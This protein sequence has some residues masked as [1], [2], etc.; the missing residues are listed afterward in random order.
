MTKGARWISSP[1]S[2]RQGTVRILHHPDRLPRLVALF[3]VFL[4]ALP[5]VFFL[6]SA[7][8]NAGSITQSSARFVLPYALRDTV[9][10]SCG[11]AILSA[12]MGAGL[13]SLVTF[14]E[15]PGVRILRFASILPLAFPTYLIAY[16]LVDIDRPS[17]GIARGSLTPWLWDYVGFILPEMRSLSGAILTFSLVLFPY[18][19]LGARIAFIAQ[20]GALIETAR[21]LGRTPFEIYR[22]IL[23]PLALPAIAAST[24]LVVMESLNDIG[25]SEYLGVRTL[26]FT[27]YTT[28]LN[29]G[30]FAAAI[31]LSLLLILAVFS[32][33]FAV[34]TLSRRLSHVQ[35][36]RVT[37]AITPFRAPH[38]SGF[39]LLI[40]GALPVLFGF[41]L[42]ALYLLDQAIITSVK[43]LDWYD[44]GFA[45][46]DSVRLALFASIGVAAIAVILIYPHRL[47]PDR[48]TVIQ[49]RIAS[50]GYAVPGVILGLAILMP[51]GAFDNLIDSMMRRTVGLSSGLLITGSALI[52]VF[53]YLVRFSSVGI[54]MAGSGYDKISRHLD[55]AARSLGRGRLASFIL[56]PTRMT[57]PAIAAA[58]LLVF[59]DVVKELPLTLILRPLGINT[60]ATRIYENASIGQFEYAS[61]KALILLLISASAV[62]LVIGRQVRGDAQV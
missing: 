10:L 62:V 43:H 8:V 57:L 4:L 39:L 3:T 20:G 6:V 46:Y 5:L 45:I 56:V 61:V 42:P 21:S 40:I 16:I 48:W 18:V 49:L 41:V 27:I 50:Y 14:V 11:V 12:V 55:I 25:A 19:Y 54:S 24:L 38:F 31:Q 34:H 36:K 15:F 33:A 44:L 58:A 26:A 60:L 1:D 2:I 32:L 59:V 47:H 13:A 17:G 51:M 29:R 53:A 9:L 35:T 28:W 52:L 23:L 37:S 22:L 7:L 30:D